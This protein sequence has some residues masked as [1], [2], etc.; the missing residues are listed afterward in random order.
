[1]NRYL[2]GRRSFERLL[3]VLAILLLLVI[4]HRYT[5]AACMMIYAYSGFVSWAYL[6]MRPG[7]NAE[8]RMKKAE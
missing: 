8:V 7:R 3:L 5:V 2:R 1:V 6:R 4:A